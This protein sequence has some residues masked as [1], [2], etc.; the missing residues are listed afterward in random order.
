[1]DPWWHYHHEPE[2]REALDLIFGDHFSRD[3]P[4]VFD[5][6]RVA[7]LTAGDPFMHLADLSS[8]TRSQERLSATYAD[9][10][11]WMR[12]SI[13][14]VAASGRFSS[15]RTITEYAADIWNV[16]PSPVL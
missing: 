16:R 5:P 8:Y 4:G 10:N 1:Y 15:D 14:N 13:L 7:L 2:T 3:E 6:I 12:K 11:A 9:P